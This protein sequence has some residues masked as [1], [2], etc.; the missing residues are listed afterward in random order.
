[1][2]PDYNFCIVKKV[3]KSQA[4]QQYESLFPQY[5]A[6]AARLHQLIKDLLSSS[7]IKYH[8]IESRA[9]SL[10]SFTEKL[11]RPEK[12]YI[13]PLVQIQ[14]LIGLRIVVY[15]ADDVARVGELI[16]K[17]FRVIEQEVAHQ[18]ESYS[19]DTFGYLSLHYITQLSKTR[20]NLVEWNVIK[21]LSFEIQVRTVLQHSWAAVSHA[22]Q[23]KHESDVPQSLRRKL[24]RL[25]GLFELADEQFIDIR[26]IG[27][28][29]RRDAQRSI[30][31]GE[32]DVLLNYET[33]T[34]FMTTWSEFP[35]LIEKMEK[36]GYIF[37][38]DQDRDNL[39]IS[40][41][42]ADCSAFGI[43]KLSDFSASISFEPTDFLSSIMLKKSWTVSFSFT[44]YLLFI[45]SHFDYYSVEKLAEDGWSRDIAQNL[46]D[47]GKKGSAN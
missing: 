18:Q 22:L 8:F 16:R 6:F 14:D 44:L 2:A 27:T 20:C 3:Q 33:L 9:K 47:G 37:D 26:N 7:D 32:D 12:D 10:I 43:S 13:N 31:A 29:A 21:D 36:M 19:V 30:S 34:A 35:A 4:I 15:Y 1:M 42:L 25:A 17:E 46:I 40:Q 11:D 45:G 28:A 24:Y 5:E 41:I 23:Y 38:N 39:Y